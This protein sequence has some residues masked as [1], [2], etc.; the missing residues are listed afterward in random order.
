MEHFSLHQDGDTKYF[1]VWG[2]IDNH[3]YKIGYA[4]ITR[5]GNL[6]IKGYPLMDKAKLGGLLASGLYVEA[7]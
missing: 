6:C 5:R 4:Y 1:S 7:E 3:K 2:Y